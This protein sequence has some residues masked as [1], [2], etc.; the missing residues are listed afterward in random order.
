MTRLLV[1]ELRRVAARRL[2]RL[3][4][5]LAIVGIALGGV[6]AFERSE[7]ISSLVVAVVGKVSRGR[8]RFASMLTAQTGSSR[9]LCRHSNA[10]EAQ[11]QSVVQRL[12]P[13]L[14]SAPLWRC[15]RRQLPT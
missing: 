1:A 13:V 11:Q 8:S 6:A 7:V 10:L 12:P 4:V 3:T 15:V 14:A 9:P 2:V 5:A